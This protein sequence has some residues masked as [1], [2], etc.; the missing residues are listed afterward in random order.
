MST[1][2]TAGQK[3]RA[4]YFNVPAVQTPDVSV[5]DGATTSTSYTNTLTTTGIIGVVFTGP[6]SGQSTVRWMTTGRAGAGA[7]T[8]TSCEVRTGS[9]I[10]SGTV[11]SASDDNT[12]SSCQS[13]SV[14]QQCEHSGIRLIT[15]LT[16]GTVYNACI[17]YKVNTGTGTYNRRS[18]FVE[19]AS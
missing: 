8:F 12:A 15:G 14:N 2:F 19:P 9:S 1:G 10:G 16:F 5:T 11:V 3:I 18:I 17:T 7:F 13:D 6:Y 4:S